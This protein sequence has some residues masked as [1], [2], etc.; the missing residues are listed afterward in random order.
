MVTA[1]GNVK[2]AITSDCKS[3]FDLPLDALEEVVNV[4][5]FGGAIIPA[6]IFGRTMIKKPEGGSIITISS[7]NAYRPLEGRPGYAAG[8]AALT[9][10]TQWL[11][12]YMAKECNP[13]LRVNCI[14]PG[15]FLNPRMEA[16]L[17]DKDGNYKPRGQ[18]IIANTPMGRLGKAEELAG[19]A[20]WLASDASKFVTGVVIPVDGGFNAYAGL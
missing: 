18:A 15:F 10:F 16:E 2:E 12:V 14:A 5:L 7:M 8:K 1:G 20:L 9:N 6:Q 17:L 19:T 4:N 3:F 13:A 11:A